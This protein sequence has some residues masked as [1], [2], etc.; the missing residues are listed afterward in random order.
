MAARKTLL[1]GI[2]LLSILSSQLQATWS[3]LLVNAATGEMGISSGTCLTSLSLLHSTPVVVVGKGL[4]VSQAILDSDGLRR[5]TMFN[6]IS[7]GTPLNQILAQLALLP[8]HQSRQYGMVDRN[9]GRIAFTGANAFDWA[10]EFAGVAS[11]P[12]GP[13]S[14][15]IQGNIL[16]GSCVLDAV[17]DTLASTDDDL[18]GVLMATM[19]AAKEAGGDGRCSCSP[20]AATSCGCPPPA[21]FKSGHIGFIVVTRTGDSD[22]PLCNAGGCASGDY[23][24]SINIGGQPASAPDPVDQMQDA[25]DLWRSSRVGL[26]DAIT[27][28]STFV[29]DDDGSR[30]RVELSDWAGGAVDVPVSLSVT[31]VPGELAPDAI[32]DPIEVQSGVWEIPFSVSPGDEPVS[33]R[34]T[35][36]DG[37]RP[38][39][40]MPDASYCRTLPSTT[41][42]DCNANGNG[43]SCDLANGTATDDDGDGILD[44]CPRF[45]RGDV[46]GDGVLDLGD[47]VWM[48]E[49]L[50]LPGT[51]VPPCI[52]AVDFD[53]GGELDLADPVSMLSYLFLGGPEPSPPFPLCGPSDG[54][55]ASVCE[56]PPGC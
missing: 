37:V 20:G 18:P 3:I 13:I 25:F 15:A 5:Q 44:S 45:I 34:V 31:E 50:Y 23:F 1:T 19:H 27:S 54:S 39:T 33:L 46:D 26:P 55:P 16:A 29:E 47:A 28:E 41:D 7:D 30:L 56:E 12:R 11:T 10:G 21:P 48:L 14:Y 40:L 43:D 9:G 22:D 36:E 49:Y 17:L 6:G 52:S 8:G 24:L 53:G 38:V 35:V 51:P 32:G 4:G 2:F 42:P